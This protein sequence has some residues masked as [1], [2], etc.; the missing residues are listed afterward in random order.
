[1]TYA[2]TELSR[3]DMD[4]LS[5]IT[6]IE[7]GAN[8][9]GHCQAAQPIITAALSVTPTL[10][11]IKIE[12]GKGRPLGRSFAVKLWPTLILLREGAEVARLVRPESSSAIQQ[13]LSAAAV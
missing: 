8:E 9:C 10:R 4:T 2:Y 3:A 11:H 7:F 5:G 13:V 6:L 12:D 1:M